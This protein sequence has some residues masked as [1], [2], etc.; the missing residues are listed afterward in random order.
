MRALNRSLNRS[1]HRPLSRRL[2]RPIIR[3]TGGGAGSHPGCLL[4]QALSALQKAVRARR[5][6][7]RLAPRV[8]DNAVVDR[9]AVEE[10]RWA[11]ER[12]GY[13][14]ALARVYGREPAASGPS[15]PGVSPWPRSDRTRRAILRELAA[16]ELWFPIG[17]AMFQRWQ[18]SQPHARLSLGLI[19]RLVRIASDL[20]RLAS[21]LETHGSRE[22]FPEENRRTFAEALRMVCGPAELT[23]VKT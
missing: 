13:E 5:R 19:G 18:E 23:G 17:M 22:F 2:D 12:A 8:F 15:F 16:Y 7:M 10:A 11:R 14:Q 6:L 4:S 20:G 9:L 3:R 1:L 21:G